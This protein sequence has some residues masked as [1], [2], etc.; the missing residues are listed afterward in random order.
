[1][2]AIAFLF[3]RVLCDGFKSRRRLEAEILVLQH[4]LNIVLSENSVRPELA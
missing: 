2:F 1:M 3:V 4:Q